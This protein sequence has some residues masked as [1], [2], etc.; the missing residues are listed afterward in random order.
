MRQDQ[1]AGGPPPDLKLRK[2]VKGV[3]PRYRTGGDCTDGAVGGHGG[4]RPAIRHDTGHSGGYALCESHDRRQDHYH[5]HGRS[6]DPE[7][8]G[9]DKQTSRGI[10][11]P[12]RGCLLRATSHAGRARTSFAQADPTQ[13]TPSR[14][15]M[16]EFQSHDRPRANATRTLMDAEGVR[17]GIQ[18]PDAMAVTF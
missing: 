10:V 2:R 16:R 18:S 14:P 8:G 1:I 5:R 15:P 9:V 12:G 3:R 4:R 6:G 11:R 17:R 7:G 13:V